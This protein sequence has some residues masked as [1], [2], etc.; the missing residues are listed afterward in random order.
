MKKDEIVADWLDAWNCHDIERIMAHYAEDIEFIAQTVV[1]RWGKADG[2]L[3]GKAELRKH[4]EKGLELAPEIHFEVDQ[5]LW[6]PNGYAA[7]YRRENNNQVLD[8][9]ELNAEGLAIK[10]TAYYLLSQA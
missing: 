6:S 7:L 4:F 5:I 2:K 1:K 8:A 9:V 10:V 3:V